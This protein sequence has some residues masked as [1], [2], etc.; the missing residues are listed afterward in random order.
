[1]KKLIF[2]FMALFITG[3]LSAQPGN[4]DKREKIEAMRVA[5]LTNKLNLSSK[6]AQNFWPVFNEYQDK[7]EALR[8]TKRKEMKV[9]KDRLDQLNDAEAAGFI[10]AEMNFR[11]KEL[12]LQKTY[13]ARFK[14]VLPLTKVAL[15]LRAEDE[16]KR[17]LLKQIKD[18][19]Q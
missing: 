5:F 3:M 8:T 2:I 11:Q 7:L 6:E 15:L 18:R 13:F 14:Q 1:M 10:D 4:G 17:E 9:F 12:E 16:F 19:G